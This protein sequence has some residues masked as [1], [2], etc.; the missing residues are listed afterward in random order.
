MGFHFGFHFRNHFSFIFGSQNGAQNGTP[1]SDYLVLM[2]NGYPLE[3]SICGSIWGSV[4]GV[5]LSQNPNFY[6]KKMRSSS[7]AGSHLGVLFWVPIL[8]AFWIKIETWANLGSHFEVPLGMHCEI[9][10]GCH[11]GVHFGAIEIQ[12]ELFSIQGGAHFSTRNGTKNRAEKSSKSGSKK[13]LASFSTKSV[14][15]S[16]APLKD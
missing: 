14:T 1:N 12:W 4:R 15:R 16:V 8:T 3:G 13:P 7:L 6:C 10:L 9:I 5:F 2:S 11:F